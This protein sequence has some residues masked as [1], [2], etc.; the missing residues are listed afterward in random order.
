MAFFKNILS[1]LAFGAPESAGDAQRETQDAAAPSVQLAV[2]GKHPA[3]DDHI[4]DI[5][6]DSQ[7]LVDLKRIFYLQGVGA[8]L[9]AGAWEKLPRDQRLSGFN[10]FFLSR[11]AGSEVIGQALASTDGK[12]RGRFP[13]VVCM[14][15][16]G[17][18]PERVATEVAPI[19]DDTLARC[20]RAKTRE[21][22]QTV[23]AETRLK[24]KGLAAAAGAR[25][26]EGA[27]AGPARAD[28]V[29]ARTA[30]ATPTLRDLARCPELRDPPDQLHSVLFQ[31]EREMRAFIPDLPERTFSK[32]TTA[33]H[34]RVPACA[35]A[36]AQAARLW[37]DLLGTRLDSSTP[38]L[39]VVAIDGGWVDL[40]VGDPRSQDFFCLLASRAMLPYTTDIPF[41][42]DA[43]FH[44]RAS[45]W[46]ARFAPAS[47]AAAS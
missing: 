31:M 40:L 34:L 35:A 44:E 20:R 42:M 9:D 7:R 4:D 24:L 22:V 6:L 25:L 16:T 28:G 14:Q 10:H 23:L 2:F 5:G 36:P 33:A 17:L 37:I 26:A 43:A 39:A 1:R 38:V 41:N 29:E 47:T 15:C 13:L 19:L 3:W 12:G 32:L 30:E 11:A 21:Q 45:R 18:A 8:N 46:V 27:A